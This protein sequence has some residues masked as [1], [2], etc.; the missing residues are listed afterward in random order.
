MASHFCNL[1]NSR[2]FD[3]SWS[4]IEFVA[5]RNQIDSRC[6]F[7]AVLLKA[8]TSSKRWELRSSR[9]IGDRIVYRDADGLEMASEFRANSWVLSR[10][11]VSINLASV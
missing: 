1:L 11:A 7:G 8:L 5:T 10:R 4:H 3:S 2:Q 6:K 9:D